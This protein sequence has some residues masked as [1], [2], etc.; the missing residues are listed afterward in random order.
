MVS[1]DDLDCLDYL[2]WLRTGRAAG[3]RLG[4]SQSSVSRVAQRVAETF[5]LYLCKY[6][7]EWQI[8]GGVD[9][10]NMERLVHQK[11]RWDAGLSPRIDAHYYSCSQYCDRLPKVW[12]SG[13]SD[14]LEV[15]AP[16]QHLRDGVIDVW[17][18]F[19][20]DVPED[21]DTDLFCVHLTRFPLYLVVGANH[22]L[23]ALR[24]DVALE[25]VKR[26]SSLALSDNA[27]PKM[28]AGLQKLGLWNLPIPIKRFEKDRWRDQVTEG[29]VIGYATPLTNDI[30]EQSCVVLPIR[31]PFEV[32]ETVVVKREYS[33]HHRFKE[34]LR[35][36]KD[37]A[38][39]LQQSYSNVRLCF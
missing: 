36:L 28:K 12:V 25:H 13:N 3:R 14:F 9:L 38:R 34:L 23:L 18:G 27:L 5:G 11:Y 29:A 33:T 6:S 39:E 2:I 37:S 15:C 32:G 24:E 30:F 8:L 16:V 26:Y 21:D 35:S 17:I 10:L 22:A 31:I 20:P 1:L 7:G 4:F 19:Y